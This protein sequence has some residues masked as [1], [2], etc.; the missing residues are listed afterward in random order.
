MD[1]NT[2]FCN[3]NELNSVIAKLIDEINP[4]KI[5]LIYGK[6]SFYATKSNS[7]D[8][9]NQSIIEKI[10]IK[11]SNP[12]TANLIEMLSLFKITSYDMIIAIGGGSIIDYGKLMIYFTNKNDIYSFIDGNSNSNVKKIPFLAIPTTFGSGSEATS[13]AV[14]YHQKTKFSVTSSFLLPSTSIICHELG[15]S[16]PDKVLGA[17]I[18]DALC[19]AIEGFWSKNSTELSREYSYKA[20]QLLIPQIENIQLTDKFYKDISL[21]SNLAGKSI[22]IAKTTAAHALSYY[23][24]ME[25]NVPHGNAVGLTIV[26]L[27]KH[28]MVSVFS[29]DFSNKEIKT[30]F[31]ELNELIPNYN[32]LSGLIN[33]LSTRFNLIMSIKE[34]SSKINFS[35]IIKKINLERLANNPVV[36]NNKDLL[37]ILE[38]S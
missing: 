38:N 11:Q 1:E 26:Q 29:N 34:L 28:N 21:A 7:L 32:F 10:I 15:S 25:H 30:I 24:T 35:N 33:N 36:I 4:K 17:T 31:K 8:V 12:D 3:F 2:L 27:F 37:K 5:F 14:L 16:M 19:Q 20:L 23:F 6:G 22:N 13:F 9:F 18:M